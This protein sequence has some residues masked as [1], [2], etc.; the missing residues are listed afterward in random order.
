MNIIELCFSK[1]W[2]GLEIY[3]ANFAREFSKANNSIVCVV[4]PVTELQLDIQKSNIKNISIIPVLKYLDVFTALKIKTI[5]KQKIDIIHVHQSKDLSTAILLKK[6]LKTPKVVY[7]QQM[8]SRYDK[9]D[10]FHKWIYKNLDQVVCM[11]DS[12]RMNHLEHTP[13]KEL[14]I[15][16][17]YNGIDLK[18]FS[19][20]SSIDRSD[21][22]KQNNIEPGRIIIGTVGRL[23][24]LKNQEL[25]I[26]AAAILIK[27]KKLDLHILIIGNETDSITGKGYK[28]KLVDRSRK[29]DIEKFISFISF[30]KNIEIYF[31]IMDIFVL[32]TNKESFGYVLIEAMSK[33][34]PVL[35]TNQGGP[36]EIIDDGKNGFLFEPKNVVDL[37]EKLF[38]LIN[39]QELRLNMS[40]ESI[41][42][43]QEKFDINVT[44]DN[45]LKLFNQI[46]KN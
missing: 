24:S 34:K 30:T 11:T 33:G 29:Y 19:S 10:L 28:Q 36:K 2:G 14:K 35:A 8:D 39:D 21:L 43:A 4:M 25:L 5:L 20:I 7:S 15:S 32:P 37:S 27:D 1:A 42:I 23:D 3:V 31:D 46:T 9:K 38:L 40:K 17:I 6:L 45:Y 13:V 12:M 18:R 26:D 44:I 16:T 41:K 22:L